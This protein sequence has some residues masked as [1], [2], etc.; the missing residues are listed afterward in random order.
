M[1]LSTRTT[2]RICGSPALTP[3]IDLGPQYLQGA[4]VKPGRSPPTEERIP[5][6]LVRC[7]PSR[8]PGR[9]NCVS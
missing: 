6:R 9:C 4:F 3:A 2:C 5:T 8:D 1:T 7:D